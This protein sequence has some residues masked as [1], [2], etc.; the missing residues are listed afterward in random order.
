[1]SRLLRWPGRVVRAAL[2]DLVTTVFPADCR[3][4]GGPL[5]RAGSLPVCDGCIGG[6]A[7]AV[8]DAVRA[9]RGGARYG[10]RAVCRDSIAGGGHCCARRAG[11]LPPEFE[12]AVA[13]GVYEDELREMVHLLKYERMRVGGGA[14]GAGCWRGRSRCW[15]ARRR[16]SWWWWRC[17]C[18]RSKERQRGYNQAVLLADAALLS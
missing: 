7:T 17:R 10:G 1:M 16:R 3:A 6:D 11:W 8:D 18:F 13:Y 4:C 2:D 12:R 14:A 5:L 15:R 9:L